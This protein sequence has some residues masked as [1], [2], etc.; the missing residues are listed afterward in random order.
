MKI[1]NIAKGELVDPDTPTLGEKFSIA[2]MDRDLNIQIADKGV[3]GGWWGDWE[4]NYKDQMTFEEYKKA[5]DIDKN[6][7]WLEK[8]EGGRI[9]KKPGG[10]VEPGVMNYGKIKD[11]DPL[12][13]HVQENLKKKFPNIKFK[14]DE[15][16]LGVPS[17]R[18]PGP[19]QDIYDAVSA[20]SRTKSIIGEKFVTSVKAEAR[21]NELKNFLINTKNN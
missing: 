16:R 11:L 8:A 12:P 9:N 18:T 1:W 2:G 20:A 17:T 4:L 7:T 15:H 10:I 3:S 19:I 5:L 6:P 21:K 13:S 14:F